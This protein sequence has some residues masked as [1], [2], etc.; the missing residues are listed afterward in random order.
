MS[1]APNGST[2]L[3]RVAAL[4]ACTW[5]LQG[6]VMH[7][8]TSESEFLLRRFATG[9]LDAT[10]LP[11]G[12]GDVRSSAAEQPHAVGRT[13]TYYGAGTDK[14]Y[15]NVGQRILIY[16]NELESET[17]YQSLVEQAFPI[18]YVDKWQTP[19]VLEFSAHADQL[20]VACQ[21]GLIDGR[22][23]EG[24]VV[25]ARYG[26][27]VMDLSG[28]VFEDRWL[29]MDQFRRVLE[30]VDAKMYRASQMQPTEP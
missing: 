11:F 12:W 25:I 3:F 15:V 20:R 24:C 23:F 14:P 27:M 21:S 10:D 18:A 5:M 6:C 8:T 1:K 7:S 26:D 28:N 19:S 29:T 9:T 16:P 17:A 22:P 4:I 13:I 30:R 2:W